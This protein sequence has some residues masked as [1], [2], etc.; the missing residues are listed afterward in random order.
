[1]F[2][3]TGDIYERGDSIVQLLYIDMVALSLLRACLFLDL[4]W[5]RPARDTLCNLKGDQYGGYA[6]RPEGPYHGYARSEL[7]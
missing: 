1:M 4:R 2:Q 5:P 7:W 6:M 3:G